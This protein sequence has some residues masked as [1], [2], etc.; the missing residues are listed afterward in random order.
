MDSSRDNPFIRFQSFVWGIGIFLLFAVL[1][2]VIWL[3]NLGERQDLEEL[4]AA[5]RLETRSAVVAGQSSTLSAEFIDAA[6]AT[7]SQQLIA[8]KPVAIEEASQL[9]P[10]SAT[11]LALVDAPEGDFAAVD[12]MT[13]SSA[14]PDETVMEIGK[15]QYLVCGACH[16]QNGE[17]GPAGPPLANSEWVTGPV[18]NLVRIQLRGMVG[19]LTVAGIEYDFP[20]GMAPMGYQTDEQIAGVLTFIRNSFGNQAP[21]V[22]AQQ[23]EALRSE[24]GKP[25]VTVADLLPPVPAP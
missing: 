15:G 22:S 10:G 7:V 11:A 4:A 14:T 23:V 16:G 18:S 25:P 12:A 6:V 5:S 8:S 21:P 19:P 20:A 13:D 3:F 1:L 24:E 2:G 9:V 17:G